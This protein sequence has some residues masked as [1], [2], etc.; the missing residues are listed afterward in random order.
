MFSGGV[1]LQVEVES[2]YGVLKVTT[3]PGDVAELEA[4]GLGSFAFSLRARGVGGHRALGV[5]WPNPSQRQQHALL[6]SEGR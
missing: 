5:S 2:A 4:G 1:L 3:I 6:V